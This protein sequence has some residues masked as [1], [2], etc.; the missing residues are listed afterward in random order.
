MCGGLRARQQRQQAAGDDAET[1]FRRQ[2]YDTL[3]AAADFDQL[4]LRPADLSRYAADFSRYF[5]E[6]DACPQAARNSGTNRF[7]ASICRYG[8]QPCG[9][10]GN[11]PPRA[12][13]RDVVASLYGVWRRRVPHAGRA[14]FAAMGSASRKSR[15]ACSRLWKDTIALRQARHLRDRQD[16]PAIRSSAHSCTLTHQPAHL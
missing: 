11:A 5:A 15:A 4:V 9:L 2:E 12:T 8:P 16:R 3:I 1:G 14:A 10:A 6:C 7:Y 13:S